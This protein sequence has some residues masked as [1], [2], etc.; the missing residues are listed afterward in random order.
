MEVEVGAR[1]DAAHGEGTPDRRG[2]RNGHRPGRGDAAGTVELP[3]LELRR[4][5]FSELSRAAADPPGPC[6][7]LL[8]MWG[9]QWWQPFLLL[10]IYKIHKLDG[11]IQ[12]VPPLPPHFRPVAE[13]RGSDGARRPILP[14]ERLRASPSPGARFTGRASRHDVVAFQSTAVC[15]AIMDCASN[16]RRLP[17]DLHGYY[18]ADMTGYLTQQPDLPSVG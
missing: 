14:F 1:T 16:A 13:T 7:Y 4:L 15:P 2:Q 11:C 12:R 8:A 18:P 17:V 9:W 10:F 3:I 5:L 6:R